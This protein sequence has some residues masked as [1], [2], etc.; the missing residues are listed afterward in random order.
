M[1]SS[2]DVSAALDNVSTFGRHFS[3]AFDE[4]SMHPTVL[5]MPLS[6][7][8]KDELARA[9]RAMQ[10]VPPAVAT[11]VFR[12]DITFEIAI[13]AGIDPE[14]FATQLQD[15]EFVV[16]VLAELGVNTSQMYLNISGVET[17]YPP[18]TP[19]ADLTVVIVVLISAG[20]LC[21]TTIV[22]CE[23]RRR[24]KIAPDKYALDDLDLIG[25]DG[26]DIAEIHAGE[27]Q[28]GAVRIELEWTPIAEL[29]I[30]FQGAHHS[31]HRLHTQSMQL[32]VTVLAAKGLRKMDVIG[33]NDVYVTVHVCEEIYT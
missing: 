17:A 13:G 19:E 20:C 18:V 5:N 25:A 9:G 3:V 33:K 24:S 16:G 6:P 28:A 30:E 4:A 23:S 7:L 11:P 8:E 31:N 22:L 21:I 14:E 32:N 15:T 27:K 29:D 12:S 2:H 1:V 10:V 26:Q